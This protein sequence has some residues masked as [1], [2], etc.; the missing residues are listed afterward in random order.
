[1]DRLRLQH[2]LHVLGTERHTETTVLT[3]DLNVQYKGELVSVC[4]RV[5]KAT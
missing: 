4:V 3:A 5:V 1:M 2:H